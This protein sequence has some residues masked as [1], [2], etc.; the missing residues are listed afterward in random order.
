MS[1]SIRKETSSLA[2]G[3]VGRFGGS[4]AGFM[5]AALNAASAT[6]REVV[7]LRVLSAGILCPLAR[8]KLSAGKFHFEPPSRFTSFDHL[9][10]G[11]EQRR[12]HFEAER[13]RRFEIDDE[14]DLRWLLDGQVCGL[15][16]LQNFI[17]VG[18]CAT[19]LVGDIWSI[20]YEPAIFDMLAITINRRQA[21]YCGQLG[22]LPAS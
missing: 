14:F 2:F 6:S 17:H 22:N 13:S 1:R 3:I 10:G 20:A 9:I 8:L 15:C 16:T 4:S 18:R 7:V 12:R 5:V 21:F 19:V 11:R